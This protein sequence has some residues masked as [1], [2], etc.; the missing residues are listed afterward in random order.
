[1]RDVYLEGGQ[2]LVFKEA[3]LVGEAL[4]LFR[5]PTLSEIGDNQLKITHWSYFE[6]WD[7]Y[8]NY[9]LAKEK[10]GLTESADTNTGTFTNFAQNDQALYSLHAYMMYLK[11]GFGRATQDAGI[12]IRRGAMHREQAVNLVRLYDGKYPE[13]FI[14]LYLD[15]YQMTQQEFDA[16]IEKWVNKSLFELKNGR[17]QPTFTIK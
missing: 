4:T 15:Y 2:D 1:M 12:E 5:F 14:D 16:I 7:P 6:N 13:Q 9:L 8:R 11:F 3:N 17:W 10:C